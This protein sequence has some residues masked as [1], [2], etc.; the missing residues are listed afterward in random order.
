MLM[1]RFQIS[2]PKTSINF[3]KG[4]LGLIITNDQSIDLH[5]STCIDLQ[6]STSSPITSFSYFAN[7]HDIDLTWSIA[8]AYGLY[9]RSLKECVQFPHNFTKANP[10]LISYFY[11]PLI[12]LSVDD[13]DVLSFD[14]GI[15]ERRFK[16]ELDF[17][18]VCDV[19]PKVVQS[20]CDVVSTYGYVLIYDVGSNLML[21][22]DS[23]M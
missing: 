9:L 21:N 19:V 3:V 10:T 7:V 14:L 15:N 4:S 16:V 2:I 8:K 23:T 11:N 12:L 5:F 1:N 13:F 17:K 22:V 18:V 20:C 6:F